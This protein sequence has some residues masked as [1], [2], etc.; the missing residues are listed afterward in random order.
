MR[1]IRDEGA[2]VGDKYGQI[3]DAQMAGGKTFLSS[4]ARTLTNGALR[5]HTDRTDVV[6]LLCVNQAA[7]GGVSTICS[8]VSVM[9]E[10]LHRR[11]DLAGL[12]FEPYFRSRHG[13]E[14]DD[15]DDVYPCQFSGYATATSPVTSR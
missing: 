9:N 2:D 3:D 8:S 13:E 14:T 5:F 11:P 4:Y 15:A 12:L 10:M 6:S 7:S 1:F